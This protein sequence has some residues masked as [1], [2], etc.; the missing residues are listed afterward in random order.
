MRDRDAIYVS[1]LVMHFSAIVRETVPEFSNVLY[2][3][4]LE[5]AVLASLTDADTADIVAE[6]EP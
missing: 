3:L 5:G 6:I 1:G 2:E 4:T